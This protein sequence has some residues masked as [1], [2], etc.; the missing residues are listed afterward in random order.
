VIISGSV[1]GVLVISGDELAVAGVVDKVVTVSAVL[2]PYGSNNNKIAEN[3]KILIRR[4]L[5]SMPFNLP[6]RTPSS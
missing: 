5:F 6:L 2:H 4:F 1:V 3:K